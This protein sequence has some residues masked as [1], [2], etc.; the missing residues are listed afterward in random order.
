MAAAVQNYDKINYHE[1]LFASI[2]DISKDDYDLVVLMHRGA[3]ACEQYPQ[4]HKGRFFKLEQLSQSAMGRRDTFT[5]PRIKW[6]QDKK[7]AYNKL[8]TQVQR[9]ARVFAEEELKCTP[10]E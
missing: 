8:K 4:S 6:P 7:K 10:K 3:A 5:D 2:D 9:G 1:H